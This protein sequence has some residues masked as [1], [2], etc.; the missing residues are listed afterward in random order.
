MNVDNQSAVG[1]QGGGVF[2][3]AD[4]A[5]AGSTVSGN[6]A[7][8]TGAGYAS[9]GGGICAGSLASKYSTIRDNRVRGPYGSSGGGAAAY[10][11]VIVGSTIS[12]NNANFSGG[13]AG[14]GGGIEVLGSGTNSIINSTISGNYAATSGG[15]VGSNIA[16]IEVTSSTIA[17]NQAKS[18]GG[19]G[20]YVHLKDIVA[21]S[22]I[23]AG[24]TASGQPS[25]VQIG[26]GHM[27]AGNNNLIVWA[28]VPLPAGTIIAD[29]LLAPLGNHGGLNRT[30]AL[31]AD[32][33]ALN[34]G[35]NLKN[36]QADGR[37]SGYSREI[38]TGAPDIGAY[39]RQVDD[40]EIYYDG[41]GS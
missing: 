28:N 7:E 18:L 20:I 32:S 27:L 21:N 12:G 15:G 8:S 36:L 29:P 22:S 17:F 19:G 1:A 34:K 25:D 39:E 4:V 41:F 38:P 6:L 14:F 9:F 3:R 13:G 26:A 31:S 16:Q 10:S 33:P 2:A 37:N 40:D 24:N 23:I 35:S 5:L 11:I 30:H